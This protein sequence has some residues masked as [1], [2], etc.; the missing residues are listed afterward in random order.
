VSCAQKLCPDDWI[1]SN[2]SHQCYYLS[3]RGS[4]WSEAEYFCNNIG[5]DLVSIRI[6]DENNFVNNITSGTLIPPWTGV[7]Y[8]QSTNSWKNIDGTTFISYWAKGEPNR[9]NGDCITYHSTADTH[10]MACTQCYDIQPALCKQAAATCNGGNFGGSTVRKGTITSPNYPNN[11]YNNLDCQYMIT[12]PSGTYI[13]IT[14]DPFI[15]ES[16]YDYVVIFDGF[17]NSTSKQIAKI[18][19]TPG[20]KQYEAT[21]NQLLVWFHSDYIINKQ[22]WSAAWEAK[23]IMP[24]IYQNGS[25][26]ELTSP[27]YPAD[28]PSWSEQ[29][30]FVTATPGFQAQLTFDYFQVEKNYDGLQIFDGLVQTPQFQVANLSG[31]T[32]IAPW[33]YTFSNNTF[34]LRFF[35][36]GIIQN[37]NCAVFKSVGTLSTQQGFETAPCYDTQPVVCKQHGAVCV[38]YNVTANNGTFTSPNYPNYYYN[39]LDCFYYITSPAGTYVAINFDPVF[40]EATLDTVSVY[41]GFQNSTGALIGKISSSTSP[42]SFESVG[43]QMLVWFHTSLLTV[44]QGWSAFWTAKRGNATIVEYGS[45]GQLNSPNYPSNYDNFLEQSY[46]V[47]ATDQFKV[48]ATIVDFKTQT[49]RD[50]L[51][52]YDGANM[53]ND[54]LVANLSGLTGVAPWTHTFSSNIFSM[55]FTSDASLQY[56]GWNLTWTISFSAD[57]AQAY[58]NSIGGDLASIYGYYERDFVMNF[59]MDMIVMPWI[60]LRR[61]LTSN[62][63]YNLDGTIFLSWWSSGLYITIYFD[64]YLVEFGFDRI[65][66]YE[67][68]GNSSDNLIGEFHTDSTDEYGNFVE[69][70]YYV[71]GPAGF[72][73]RINVDD[74]YTEDTRDYLDIFNSTEVFDNSTLVARL[75]GYYVAPWNYTFPSNTF[76]MRFMSDWLVSY[77]GFHATWTIVEN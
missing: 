37:G 70:Y 23:T 55:R 51:F 28:Y 43:N 7:Y 3:S 27:L 35:S 2:A 68:K 74:F 18:T 45:S 57:D 47:N 44:Q 13:T 12:S 69:Q 16:T 40:L 21:G 73:V 62:S 49:N 42:H 26:G 5:G 41:E 32:G 56:S 38:P 59:T 61:N 9:L 4:S 33:N 22:G 71:Y 10:G 58:C 66:V 20:R 60:G 11:Y 24:S 52:I 36:D 29:L 63:W 30:Y 17:E 31:T 64:P 48:Q 77:R 72:R 39:N 1:F 8:N 15:V 19:G 75:T 34:S 14:F 54:N 67:G 50:Y 46:L 76:G 65:R 25:S 53:T 6:S